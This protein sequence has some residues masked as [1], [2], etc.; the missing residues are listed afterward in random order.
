L[1]SVHLCE[2]KGKSLVVAKSLTSMIRKID[3][4]GMREAG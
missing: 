1:A 2:G 3:F 4:K